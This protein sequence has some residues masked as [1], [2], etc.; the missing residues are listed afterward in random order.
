MPSSVSSSGNRADP[1]DLEA[2]SCRPRDSIAD[3][4]VNLLRAPSR[5]V[6]GRLDSV[7]KQSG[8]KDKNNQICP[9]ENVYNDCY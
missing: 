8:V 9:S 3:S 6:L 7:R 1:S 4:V 2:R 5:G